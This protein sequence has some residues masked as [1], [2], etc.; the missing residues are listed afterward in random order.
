VSVQQRQPIAILCRK[1]PLPLIPSACGYLQKES[2]KIIF[3]PALA[4]RVVFCH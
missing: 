3:P 2:S 4:R 1:I